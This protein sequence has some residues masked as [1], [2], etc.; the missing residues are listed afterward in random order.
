M[1]FEFYI[2]K[3]YFLPTSRRIFSIFSN[4]LCVLGVAIGI[5]ALII[6]LGVTNG[7]HN[8]I[9]SRLLALSPHI[10]I[11]FQ[12]T[13]DDILK[14]IADKKYVV[15][16]SIYTVAQVVVKS[17]ASIQGIVLKGIDFQKEKNV[18]SL[19]KIIRRGEWNS[20]EIS[21]GK[22]L[23]KTLNVNIGDEI[24]LFSKDTESGL[25]ILPKVT[26]LKVGSI[27]ACGIY[28]YDALLGFVDIS[29]FKSIIPQ[30]NQF[31]GVKVKDPYMVKKYCENLKKS[32]PE[33]YITSWMER[34]YNLF[35]AIKLEKILGFII[36]SLIVIVACLSISSNLLLFTKDKIKDIGTLYAIGLDKKR[37]ARVF[38]FLGCFIGV[39]GI[40]L[41]LLIGGVSLFLLNKYEFIKLPPEV[42]FIEKI[43]ISIAWTDF[44]LVALVAFGLIIS[45][46]IY[47][48]RRITQMDP[49]EIIR[50]G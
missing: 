37:L 48:V 19:D 31:I 38:I 1:K 9:K 33:R 29:L 27:F 4:L 34:N 39:C 18:T 7:F 28:D 35:A 40:M 23:A 3:K 17:K 41:G 43:P 13:P 6:T 45:V 11:S 32:F 20:K 10:T 5:S 50:Y 22:E 8:E 2:A 14:I 46:L 21:L 42:Y 26:R 15:A 25:G 44:I 47:P 12:D 16:S 24:L 49:V 36:V 30:Y